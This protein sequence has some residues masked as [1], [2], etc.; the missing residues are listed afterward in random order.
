MFQIQG[1]FYITDRDLRFF[2]VWVPQDFLLE[3][4]YYD[5]KIWETIVV[6]LESFFLNHFLPKQVDSRRM[7]QP[8]LQYSKEKERMQVM[9]QDD[10]LVRE[11]KVVR[12]SKS[13][14]G[15]RRITRCS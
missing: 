5:K 4:I 12:S 3:H 8:P 2:I 13:R 11:D 9:A 1:Q 10:D 6:A 14:R 15:T 7:R